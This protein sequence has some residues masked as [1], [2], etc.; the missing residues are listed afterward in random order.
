MTI[1]S[2]LVY[3]LI[4]KFQH[5]KY[6]L[7]CVTHTDN[8]FFPYKAVGVYD[9]NVGYGDPWIAVMGG[10]VWMKANSTVIPISHISHGITQIGAFQHMQP[11]GKASADASEFV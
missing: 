2:L 10:D 5:A 7:I 6:M 1:W 3:Q 9:C 11:R 4:R 8:V